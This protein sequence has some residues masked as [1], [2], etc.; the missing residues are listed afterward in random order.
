ME[1]FSYFKKLITDD[2]IKFIDIK[3][4][5]FIGLLKHFTYP[6]S[7][8]DKNLFIDGVG[9]DGSSI[10]GYAVI[11]RSDI[12]II[13]DIETGF[14]DPFFPE[15][16]ISFLGNIK[17]ASSDEDF[18]LCPRAT[19]AR[20]ENVLKKLGIGDQSLWIPE[21]EFFL[22]DGYSYSLEPMSTYVEFISNEA[23]TAENFGYKLNNKRGYASIP[24]Y[25][26][27]IEFRTELS[28]IAEGLDI[29]IKVHHH[30]CGVPG[31]LE[32]ELDTK[33]LLKSADDILTM[34][35]L[36]KN[37][38]VKYNKIATFMP[39]P[40]HGI[41]GSGMHLHQFIKKENKNIF[42]GNVIS[43]LSNEGLYY[44]GGILKYARELTAITNAST[45]SY[46]RLIPGFEAPTVICYSNSNRTS[47]LR[48][49]GY[50]K[51]PSM[52]RIEYRPPDATGNPYFTLSA[53]LT[54]GMEGITDKIDP[55][56]PATGNLENAKRKFKKL[57]KNLPMA[58]DFLKKD[59]TFLTKNGIFKE[60]AIKHWI[61]L[62]EKEAASV[63]IYPNP[64][65]IELYFNF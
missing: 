19:A 45:N 49:P 56:K 18:P 3:V 33:P 40:M 7:K 11:E 29:G 13:P 63:S 34:K 22:F 6:I 26:K 9:A 43:D 39:K 12:R 50:I 1:K 23:N 36:I 37:L 46:R 62:K 55:G 10:G 42:D 57:P 52:R 2:D 4:V 47:A 59:H 48:I 15:K 65:E 61:E 60:E 24:P 8:F 51:D 41:S 32:F 5:N 21:L 30:E 28:K 53:L 58:L 25:D 35:Y 20:S 16:T 31:Q 14:I 27:S 38:A 17:Y 54:A 64:K 44:I